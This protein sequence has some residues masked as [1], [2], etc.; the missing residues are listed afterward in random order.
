MGRT[1][2][3][4]QTHSYRPFEDQC[5]HGWDGKLNLA[6]DKAPSRGEPGEPR[7]F[8]T[9]RRTPSPKLRGTG[10]NANIKETHRKIIFE[11]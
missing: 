1:H 10:N 3:H 8:H 2:T 7:R 6:Q 11:V 9:D 4:T 5:F